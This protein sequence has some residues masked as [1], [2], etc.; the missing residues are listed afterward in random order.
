M[1]AGAIIGA[2]LNV[3]QGIINN[4]WADYRT[5]KDRKQNYLYNEA[6]AIN[7]DFRTRQLYNDF[8][9]P[10]ALVKQYNEAGLSPS[11]MFGGTPGQGGTAGA[12]GAGPQGLQTP[13][14]PISLV[15]AAQ[16]A[17]LFAQAEKTKAETETEKGENTLGQARI[18]E[19]LANT[20]NLRAQQTY[21]NLMSDYQELQNYVLDNTKDLR[22]EE[23][24]EQ[25][26]LLQGQA[27]QMKWLA[28]TA[29]LE[30]EFN[31][32]TYDT[33]V[34][35]MVETLN[36]IIADTTLKASQK[37]LTD[38][39][40]KEIRQH[41]KY[42]IDDI[43]IKQSHVNNEY[44]ILDYQKNLME[45]QAEY[46]KQM[47]EYLP[48]TLEI[49][50]GRTFDRI[51]DIGKGLLQIGGQMIM[52]YYLKGAK[53]PAAGTPI[54]GPARYNGHRGMNAYGWE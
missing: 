38:E 25:V 33:R 41:I 37:N 32:E 21:T 22:I 26:E 16:A 27:K 49:N 34:K 30:F 9:S 4:A 11:L 53:V 31:Q 29:K 42:M 40:I 52:M 15:D 43:W 47:K 48:K 1:A 6:A 5:E 36:N 13:Y 45:A 7:A 28:K 14:M 3:G 19:I 46:Y 18:N 10:T 50:E 23:V 44:F 39:Q 12:Q 24:E 2:A 51:M 8:Y 35:T 20:G 54:T 17:A